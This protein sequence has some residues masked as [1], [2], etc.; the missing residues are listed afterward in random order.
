[1]E[2][3]IVIPFCHAVRW[4]A[5]EWSHSRSHSEPLI[6]SCSAWNGGKCGVWS[7]TLGFGPL[8]DHL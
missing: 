2:N 1:M 6:D 5:H 3:R 8:L 7:E 4:L